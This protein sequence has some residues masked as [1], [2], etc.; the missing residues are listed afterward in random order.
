MQIT[1]GGSTFS[2]QTDT[3]VDANATSTTTPLDVSEGHDLVAEIRAASGTHA[4]HVTTIQCSLDNSS[5]TDTA[6]TKTG[7]GVI[8]AMEIHSKW[9]RAKITTNE[10][11]ASTVDIQI[12]AK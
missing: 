1:V 3:G 4:T 5:W 9:V 11:G 12:Q 6:Y 7:T 8:D 10:G 2:D